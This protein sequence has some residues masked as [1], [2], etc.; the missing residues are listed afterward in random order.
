M[1]TFIR[2][3]MSLLVALAAFVVAFLAIFAPCYFETC[4]TLPMTVREA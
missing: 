4:T 2:A 1:A 3:I